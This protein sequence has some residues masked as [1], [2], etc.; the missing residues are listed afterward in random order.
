[1]HI[2]VL[3]DSWQ[4]QCCGDAHQVGESSTFTV[5]LMPDG[6]ALEA[7]DGTRSRYPSDRHNRVPEGRDSQSVTGIVR[8]IHAIECGVSDVT[9]LPAGG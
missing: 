3:I 2:E 9:C 4:Q 7:T 5:F 6:R 8:D 1:M